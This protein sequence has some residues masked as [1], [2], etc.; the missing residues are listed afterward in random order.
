MKVGGNL[1]PQP[2]ANGR[3][4]LRGIQTTPMQKEKVER[5]QPPLIY[6]LASS[7]LVLIFYSSILI[8]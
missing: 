4:T 7:Y 5:F 8:I 3:S 6:L 1:R 2:L